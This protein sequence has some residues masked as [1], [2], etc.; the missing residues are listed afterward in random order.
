MAIA[1][2]VKTVQMRV[3]RACGLFVSDTLCVLDFAKHTSQD[4]GCSRRGDCYL[5]AGQLDEFE[6]FSLHDLKVLYVDNWVD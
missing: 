2:L 5:R 3:Q 6:F 4:V 1:V